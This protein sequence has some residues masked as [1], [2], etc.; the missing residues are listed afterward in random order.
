LGKVAISAVITV[1]MLPEF[2]QLGG[3]INMEASYKP[4][5]QARFLVAKMS[6]SEKK[7]PEVVQRLS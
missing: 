7:L 4:G 1:N 6:D 5:P 2:D 3:G